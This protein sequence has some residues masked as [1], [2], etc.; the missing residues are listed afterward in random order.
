MKNFLFLWFGQLISQ[1]GSRM[2]SFALVLFSYSTTGTAMSLALLSMTS[3]LPEVL[4][5]FLGG[6]VAD[7]WNRKTLMLVS[8]LVSAMG[9][10]CILLLYQADALVT[11]HLY[12]INF[13]V[14]MMNAFQSPAANAALSQII[15][16]EHYTRAAGMQSFSN[17]FNTLVCPALAAAVVGFGGLE[18][19]L[20]FD[21]FSFA[22][23]AGMLLFLVRIP[24]IPA[25]GNQEERGGMFEGFRFLV[26]ERPAM[27]RLILFFSFINLLAA[28]S[29]NGL[30]PAMVLSRTGGNELA[31]GTVSSCIGV[32]T[33]IGSLLTTVLP[34]PHKPL[35][36]I[37]VCCALSFTLCDLMW[38]FTRTLPLWCLGAILGNL[39][40]PMLNAN[41]TAL[42]RMQIPMERQGRVFAVQSALQYCTIPAGFLLG[43]WLC[44]YVMEPL[45]AGTSA[46]A[47]ML[48]PIVGSGN[49]SGI[50]LVFLITGLA[51]SLASLG[52]LRIK[53][54]QQL[55]TSK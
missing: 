4:F 37:F 12:V 43:G 46:F 10:L 54:Y 13:I 31:L 20:A 22:V 15:P 50:A 5:T 18:T 29:G 41:L 27:L 49:G 38:G 19:V 6:A 7:R 44:D 1:L 8:D 28:M 42:M 36:V 16:Q 51:G 14:G 21:L 3:Y 48:R 35:K 26:K 25:S 40:L 52:E 39:P 23:G 45:M 47:E 30:M 9:T 11:W 24:S 55:E 32:G 2:T 34:K 17:A 33:L 53:L